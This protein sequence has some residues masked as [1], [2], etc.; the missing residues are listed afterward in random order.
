MFC[1]KCGCQLNDGAKFC[2]QCGEKVIRVDAE[3]KDLESQEK[4]TKTQVDSVAKSPKSED[5]T[6]NDHV[7]QSTGVGDNTTS[8]NMNQGTSSAENNR[9]AQ[10]INNAGN[11]T[12]NGTKQGANSAGNTTGVDNEKIN[13]KEFLTIENI[14][15]FA[16]AAAL[17]PL[18]MAVVVTVLGGILFHILSGFALG[19]AIYKVLFFLLKTLFIVATAAATA[20]L[21]YIVINEKDVALVNSWITPVVTFMAFLSCM[22][23]ALRWGAVAWIFGIIA[24]IFGLE[25]LARI[26]IDG[27][28]IDSAI[29]PGAAFETY[30]QY[31]NNYKEKY[32]T[33]KDLER[34]GVEDPENSKF[35]GTGLQVLGYTLLTILVSAITCGI[36]TPWMICKIYKWRTSHTVINGKRLTFTGSGGSLL[37][38]WILW[39]ILT[40]VT[41][42]IYGFFTYVALAKWELKHTFIEGEPI[43]ANGNESYFDG[44]SFA[45]FGYGL[46][47]ILLCIVTCGLAS[48]WVIAMI[49]K[50]YTKHEV[51]NNRRLVFSGSGLGFLGEY[52]IIF[53]LSV[54]TCGIYSSW[55]IVR[56]N[57]YIIRHTDFE[58]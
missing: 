47:G 49:Q 29:N 48:P 9:A 53:I 44:N 30:K 4:E 32:P 43:V 11:T 18:A 22:G 28:P 50:W 39:E 13:W 3:K 37:G 16:P 51:I 27:Q 23:I 40:I 5:C 56:M 7:V 1:R 26:V 15:R 41:C 54:I 12:S 2:P 55:G 20:G 34:A 21:V 58:N 31:Y 42:G 45:F 14:E 8:N 24:F 17:L 33:T 35:D 6:S 19:Y 38:H 57:K 52:L 25:F 36:A 10:S 46:L